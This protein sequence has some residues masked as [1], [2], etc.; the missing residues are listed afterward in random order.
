MVGGQTPVS[1]ACPHHKT[2]SYG[3]RD[4]GD[5]VHR[6]CPAAGVSNGK[7]WLSLKPS[8]SGPRAVDVLGGQMVK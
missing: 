8:A 2:S 1:R 3:C 5:A 6:Y 7:V 4:H